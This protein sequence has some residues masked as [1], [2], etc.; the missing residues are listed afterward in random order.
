MHYTRN[1]DARMIASLLW[2]RLSIEIE[3]RGGHIAHTVDEDVTHVVCVVRKD[4]PLSVR[5]ICRM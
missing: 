5:A 2:D 3:L 1:R 4:I